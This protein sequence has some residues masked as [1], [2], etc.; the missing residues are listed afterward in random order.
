MAWM[1][2]ELDTRVLKSSWEN[3]ICFFQNIFSIFQAR[4]FLQ[5]AR[6]CHLKA[7]VKHTSLL[8]FHILQRG[9]AVSQQGGGGGAGGRGGGEEEEED[10]A[11]IVSAEGRLVESITASIA[12]NNASGPDPRSAAAL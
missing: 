9:S 11:G 10:S 8:S 4:L 7:H 1:T 2:V 5:L 12:A 6:V 3:H